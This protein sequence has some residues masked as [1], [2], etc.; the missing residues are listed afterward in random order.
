MKL[1]II[2]STFNRKDKL[3]RCINSIFGQS[4]KL[5]YEILIID[6]NS[7]DGTQEMF[8]YINSPRIKYFRIKNNGGKIPAVN[9]GLRKLQEHT[10]LLLMMMICFIKIFSNI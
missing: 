3:I 8:E 2:I 4:A 7:N 1:S 6:D 10:L 5:N 9:Y